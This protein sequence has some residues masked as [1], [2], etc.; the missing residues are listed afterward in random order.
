MMAEPSVSTIDL[1]GVATTSLAGYL[2]G[3][4]ILRIVALQRDPRVRG[5]W[6]DRGRFHLTSTLDEEGLEQ[7]FC[8]EYRPT[9]IV[10]PWNKD[11][12]FAEDGSVVKSDMKAIA[13]STDPRL[14]TFREVIAAASRLRG[15]QAESKETG[16]AAKRAKAEFIVSLRSNLP[17]AGLAWLDVCWAVRSGNHGA[18]IVPAPLAGAGGTDGRL[19]FSSAYAQAVVSVFG[20]RWSAR[21]PS[22]TPALL[23]Q[24]LFGASGAAP[25][26]TDLTSGLYDPSALGGPNGTSGDAPS[27][28][29]NPWDVLFMMEGM[30]VWGGSA[31]RHLRAQSRGRAAFPFTFAPSAGGSGVSM[32]DTKDSAETWTPIWPHPAPFL[33]I[34]QLFREGRCEWRSKAATGAADVARAVRSLGV[35][36]GIAAFDR[37]GV[38]VRNGRSR[39]AVPLARFPVADEADAQVLALSE[40]DDW[41]GRLDRALGSKA[42]WV[43]G[44]R[45]PRKRIDDHLLAYCADGQTAHLQDLLWA[46]VEMERALARHAEAFER[47]T[48]IVPVPLPYLNPM[49]LHVLDL[50][51]ALSLAIAWAS[52]RGP[53]F[54]APDKALG[55]SARSNPRSWIEPV[56]ESGRRPTWD[57]SSL[58]CT[59]LHASEHPDL[60]ALALERVLWR[61]QGGGDAEGEWRTIWASQPL[62]RLDALM[63]LVTSDGTYR[64]FRRLMPLA[65][66]FDYAKSDQFPGRALDHSQRV[67]PLLVLFKAVVQGGGLPLALPREGPP[68]ADAG[69]VHIP[70][71]PQV[72][73]LLQ[74]A[75][76]GHVQQAARIAVQRIFAS[77]IPVPLALGHAEWSLSPDQSRRMASALAVPVH[78]WA[79]RRALADLWP[80]DEEPP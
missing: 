56:S 41:L 67:H 45:D 30:L 7:F 20:L 5:W 75:D 19:D 9:P 34:Q 28:L 58:G 61:M 44:V 23:K 69:V 39:L 31:V 65:A 13:D 73:R 64:E 70:V 37:Y 52:Q 14:L 24:A 40:L 25:L 3:L 51:P 35:Q 46:L 50:S 27:R 21:S 54:A 48:D 63:P 80:T 2:K 26:D 6:D 76:P 16:A 33:E 18:E 59:L 1:P 74:S 4:G 71:E 66:L 10:S 11:G 77:G 29:T 43:A 78:P 42:T 17:D 32:A 60:A 53:S 57:G 12:G 8:H 38:Q 15:T 49:L 62:R 55:A 68:R 47:A 22:P 79:L 72:V 36:R